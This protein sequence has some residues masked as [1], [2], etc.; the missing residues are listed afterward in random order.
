[1]FSVPQATALAAVPCAHEDGGALLSFSIFCSLTSYVQLTIDDPNVLILMAHPALSGY[2]GVCGC[3]K[4]YREIMRSNGFLDYCMKVP[5]SEEKKADVKNLAGKNRP[6]NSKIHDIFKGWSLQPLDPDGRVKIWV[7]GVSG[8]GFLI[9]IFLVFTSYL[10]CKKP[11][12]HQSTPPQQKPLTL[13]YD[14]DL[15]M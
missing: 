9:M 6:V 8:G 2:G 15:D 14:G 4:G 12:P 1:M 5:G 11:K 13:A 3:E 7:Y 10:L